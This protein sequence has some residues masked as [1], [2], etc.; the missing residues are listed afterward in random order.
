MGGRFSREA[1]SKEAHR[2]GGG[3]R[4]ADPAEKM[5]NSVFDEHEKAVEAK[6]KRDLEEGVTASAGSGPVVL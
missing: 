3:G 6:R 1:P 2:A 5:V 4:A